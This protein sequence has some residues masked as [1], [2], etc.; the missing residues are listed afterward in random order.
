M[1]CLLSGWSCSP[2]LVFACPNDGTLESFLA[3]KEAAWQLS[4]QVILLD[5]RKAGSGPSQLVKSN[6]NYFFSTLVLNWRS[7][8]FA[9]VTIFTLIQNCIY[10]YGW[11]NVLSNVLIA[12][13]SHTSWSNLSD[14][15]HLSKLTILTSTDFRFIL[16]T[17]RKTIGYLLLLWWKWPGKQIKLLGWKRCFRKGLWLI[18]NQIDFY[19]VG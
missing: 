11:C 7:L 16:I 18:A 1:S 4:A 12:F 3:R 19:V 10:I 17:H 2:L 14:K 15:L 13:R 9:L 6:R 5:T 8:I